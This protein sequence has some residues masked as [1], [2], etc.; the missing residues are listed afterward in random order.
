MTECLN[1]S[2]SLTNPLCF[3]HEGAVAGF[4][5]KIQEMIIFSCYSEEL[6][7]PTS[8]LPLVT[9]EQVRLGWKKTS[10]F[11]SCSSSSLKLLVGSLSSS[12]ERPSEGEAICSKDSNRAIASEIFRRRCSS[13]YA[14]RN[15]S[16][17]EVPKAISVLF[18]LAEPIYDPVSP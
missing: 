3:N 14:R 1:R 13:A 8:F 10:Y 18:P 7:W 2:A 16:T 6:L 9:R 17:R 11:S 5:R 12:K 15:F 4:I